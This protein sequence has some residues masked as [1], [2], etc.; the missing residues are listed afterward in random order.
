MSNAPALRS[1]IWEWIQVALLGANLIWT[2]LCLGGFR[3]ETMVVTSMLTGLLF[4]VHLLARA[5]AAAARVWPANGANGD[6]WRG[7]A[8][9]VER[10]EGPPDPDV[11][12]RM[13]GGMEGTAVLP[14]L[15]RKAT[16]APRPGDV[17]LHPASWLVLPFLVYAAANV[18]WISPVPWLGWRDW[19]GWAQL[20]IMFW[21]ALNGVRSPA[22][23]G[24]LFTLLL[25]LGLTAV[26]LGCYQRFVRPDWLMLGRTQVQ[27]FVGRASGSFGIPNSLAALLLLLLPPC[28]ALALRRGASAVQRVLF[29]YVAVVFLLGLGLTVSRGAWIS[30]AVVLV[31]WP[32]FARGGSWRRRLGWTAVVGV[33]LGAIALTAFFQVDLV[34]ERWIKL[35]QDSG[36]LSRPILWR[37]A[38]RIFAEHP[39]WGSGA[40]SFAVAFE[41]HRPATFQ[42]DPL[43]AHNDYLNT[44]SDYGAVGF[45]LCFGAW[46][47]VGWG[48]HRARKR[49]RTGFPDQAA[50]HAAAGSG[51][52]ALQD[53]PVTAAGLLDS[54]M[55]RRGLAAG[56]V[57]F[58]LQL[59]V[60]FHFKIPALALAF[61]VVAALYVQA[62]WPQ[63]RAPAERGDF[64]K[65]W[66][67]A[68]VAFATLIGLI[69]HVLPLYRAEALRYDAR[70]AIDRLA[71]RATPVSEWRPVLTDALKA[72]QRANRI[73]PTNA[74]AW[75]DLSYVKALFAWI[76]PTRLDAFAIEAEHAADR[77]L[78]LSKADPE[79]WIRRGVALDM[80]RRHLEAGA[81]FV[82][83]VATAPAWAGAWYHHA[84]HLSLIPSQ[85]GR[86]LAAV[87]FCL[88]LDAGNREAQALRRRL[89]ESGGAP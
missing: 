51:D 27:Q 65:A 16:L 72:L 78:A 37:G 6:E 86:A 60:D 43:W 74:A 69:G 10:A 88:R 48:A 34:R 32:L 38:W 23:R 21:V 52:S 25:L 8:P 49:G 66:G 29:G 54:A 53:P 28:C 36:E 83:A 55:F 7:A 59:F 13:S 5:D 67:F 30:L 9:A 57:A 77:A 22:A 79:F 75:A 46:A 3:A 24:T 2:T 1:L 15:T 42:D 17:S 81:A 47:V 18:A 44:L 63:C 45:T 20:G 4:V 19:F 85:R 71:V 82:Q 64:F 56:L 61:A 12:R 84:F 50:L 58:A 39:V 89:T 40:G 62:A 73:D 87:E 41:K 26:V 31:A 11:A 14:A 70:R 68:A 33:T 35:K 76:E 80:R